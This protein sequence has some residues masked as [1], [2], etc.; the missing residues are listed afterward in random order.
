M[1]ALTRREL[2][3]LSLIA[4]GNTTGSIASKL[5]IQINTVKTHRKNMLKKTGCKNITELIYKATKEGII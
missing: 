2:E 5:S 4:E 3:V 1:E